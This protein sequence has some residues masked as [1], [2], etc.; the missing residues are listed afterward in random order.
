MWIE[1]GKKQYKSFG[2]N[3]IFVVPFAGKNSG[4]VLQIASSP[5]DAEFSGLCFDPDE[6]RLF[7]SVQHP[8]ELSESKKKPTSLWPFDDDNVPKPSVVA[9]TGDLI[10]KMNKLNQIEMA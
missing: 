8:G 7:A 9:I 4:R 10:E 6:N 2:N 3:G 1:E 5:N